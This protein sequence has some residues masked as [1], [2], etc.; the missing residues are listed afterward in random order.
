[1]FFIS[2]FQEC[3]WKKIYFKIREK[4]HHLLTKQIIILTFFK[5]CINNKIQ[6][7]FKTPNEVFFNF[8]DIILSKITFPKIYFYSFIKIFYNDL[9]FKN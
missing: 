4:I 1:M 8:Q 2:L 7:G 3:F 9:F 5:I 6:I